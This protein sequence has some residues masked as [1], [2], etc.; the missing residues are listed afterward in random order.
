MPVH[1][2]GPI[3]T[4]AGKSNDVI[5]GI[6]QQGLNSKW[7]VF[8]GG[9]VQDYTE[10]MLAHRDNKRY[11]DWSLDHMTTKLTDQFREHTI[12]TIKPT[13]MERQ[14]FSCYDN[15]VESNSVGAPTHEHGNKASKHLSDL[16]DL[17]FAAAK[18]NSPDN[19]ESQTVSSFDK[20]ISLIG[21][22]KGCV[23]LNQLIT[24][25]AL[26]QNQDNSDLKS[27]YSQIDSIYWLDGGHA[28]GK[29]TWITD[30]ATVTHL[31]KQTIK[32]FI[33]VTP[34]QIEDMMRPWIG[35]EC[36]RFYN[37]L[38]RHDAK[39]LFTKHF[40]GD[41]IS[42]EMHFALLNEFSSYTL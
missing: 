5:C 36:K 13:R 40:V 18:E 37:I 34:Y 33:H 32:C 22:S 42:L 35:Q 17:S 14:I 23:V 39:V 31:S 4:L 1:R 25:M 41:E 28:G 10:K 16:L 38:R 19:T 3:S 29:N 8:F 7:L 21:F 12:F 9:D 6:G 2:L 24:E 15:F 11:A 20:S 26:P 27:F 30:L